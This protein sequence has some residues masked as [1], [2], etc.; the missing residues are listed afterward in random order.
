VHSRCTAGAQPMRSRFFRDLLFR[1][2][3][4]NEVFV[5]LL[6]ADAQLGG[7]TNLACSAGRSAAGGAV[8]LL[9]ARAAEAEHGRRQN[10][11]QRDEIFQLK[12]SGQANPLHGEPLFLFFLQ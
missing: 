8:H 10:K 3:A 2:A 4:C 5:P 11:G 7:G 12:T 9:P 6:E 1:A